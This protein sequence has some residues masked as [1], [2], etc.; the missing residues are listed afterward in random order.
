MRCTRALGFLVCLFFHQIV[1]PPHH[2]CT[3]TFCTKKTSKIE[4]LEK[5]VFFKYNYQSTVWTL[6]TEHSK[7]CLK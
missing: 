2:T 4:T 6:N 3:H 1:L 5:N 7:N